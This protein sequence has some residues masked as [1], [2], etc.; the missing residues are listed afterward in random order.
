LLIK[1]LYPVRCR[2]RKNRQMH[3]VVDLI[4]VGDS[5][6]W[7]T[8]RYRC[9]SSVIY[10]ATVESSRENIADVKK[11]STRNSWWL[12]SLQTVSLYSKLQ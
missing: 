4:S 11:A 12:H 5:R 8:N 6:S 2:R 10:C 3:H 7:M 1:R 9:Y